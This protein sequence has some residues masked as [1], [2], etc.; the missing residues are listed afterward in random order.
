MLVSLFFASTA[1]HATVYHFQ[2][3]LSGAAE[4]VPNASPGTGVANVYF[5]DAAQA[6]QVKIDFGGLTANTTAAHIHAAT[7]L[8]N[9]G[10][11]GVATELPSFT[12]FP[13]GVTAG[14]YD[15]W[16]DLTSPAT[17]SVA[18]TTANGGTVAGAS[19]GF[20]NALM[21]EKSYLN[22]HTTAFPAGEIRGFLHSVPDASSTA[23]LLAI[24]LGGMLCFSRNQRQHT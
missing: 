7:A 14:S 6:M 1:A 22:I 3:D 23:I 19:A 18:F 10:T 4:G 11:T 15:H 5:D 9:T 16:F 20:L 12:G 21:A 2:A 8:P 17:F 24:A 13:L